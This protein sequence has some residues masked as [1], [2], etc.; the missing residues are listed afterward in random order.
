M[1]T[2]I[3]AQHAGA[4]PT[5]PNEVRST[6]T[7]VDDTD[8]PAVQEHTPDWNETATDPDTLGGLTPRQLA[9]HV[10]PS[11]RYV[12]NV[13]ASAQDEHNAIVN[14]QVSTSGVA[15]AKEATGEWGHGT[16]KIVEGIEPVLH[17][18]ALGSDYFT[19]HER[20][21]ANID[22]LTPA[23]SADPETTG[24]A[25]QQANAAARRAAQAS[26]YSAYLSNMTGA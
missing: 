1:S 6:I 14:R 5:D 13:G 18:A 15:P 8:P 26:M 4:V 11:D 24:A 22:G 20:Q 25:Q 12:P 17:D 23:Q 16:L 10:I 21:A 3:I 9:S 2:T 7:R 19:G